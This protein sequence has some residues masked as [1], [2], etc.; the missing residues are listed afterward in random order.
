MKEQHEF[1]IGIVQQAVQNLVFYG[2]VSLLVGIL[3]IIY[4]NLLGILVGLMLVVAAVQAFRFAYTLNKYS[5][6]KLGF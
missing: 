6:I 2:V 1:V 4:P 5:R 3:I